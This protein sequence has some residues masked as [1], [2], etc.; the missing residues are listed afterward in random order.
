M[1][2]SLNDTTEKCVSELMTGMERL[3]E[4]AEEESPYTERD[5]IQKEPIQED[6]T[7]N[8]S[9]L[10]QTIKELKS[11]M[12]SVKK[13]N[14]RILRAQKELNHILMER[15][16]TEG[17]DNKTDSEDMGY[18]HKDKKTKQVKNESGSSSEVYGDLHKQ[19]FHYTSDSSEDNHHTRN[20]KFKPYEISGEFKK[21][22]PSTFNR[23]NEKGEEAES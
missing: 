16:H 10:L 11:E 20:R 15:F 4:Y 17:K 14:E 2:F 18:Q 7:N 23:E 1:L 21:I 5:N 13:E 6:I 3:E 9:E 8:S 12:E 22:K 19:N